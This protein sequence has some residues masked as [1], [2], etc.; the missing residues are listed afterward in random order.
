MSKRAWL[1]LNNT[2]HPREQA[3]EVALTCSRQLAIS[4]SPYRSPTFTPLSVTPRL[5]GVS[6]SALSGLVSE[7]PDNVVGPSYDTAQSTAC[8]GTFL[9]SARTRCNLITGVNNIPKIG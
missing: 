4:G 5:S 3:L 2:Q 9:V 8:G 1:V 6:P 7:L